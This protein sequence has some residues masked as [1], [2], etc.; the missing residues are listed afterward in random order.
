[1]TTCIIDQQMAILIHWLMC[2]VL[3][4][5]STASYVLIVSG[6]MGTILIIFLMR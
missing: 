1:M 3:K 6:E 4:P 5:R 2:L